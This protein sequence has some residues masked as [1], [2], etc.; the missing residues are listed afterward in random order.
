MVRI[1]RKANRDIVS[2]TYASSSSSVESSSDSIIVELYWGVM[3]KKKK[4]SLPIITRI[5]DKVLP[6]GES[7]SDD[8]GYWKETEFYFVRKDPDIADSFYHRDLSCEFENRQEFGHSGLYHKSMMDAE[9]GDYAN[10]NC[11]ILLLKD[12][13]NIPEMDKVLWSVFHLDEAFG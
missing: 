10:L 1:K 7:L 11:S 12:E 6:P 8:Q 4:P 5:V 13:F 3:A 2:S 9:F